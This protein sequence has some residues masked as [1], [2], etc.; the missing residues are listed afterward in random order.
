MLD[1]VKDAGLFLEIEIKTDSLDIP[2]TL[3]ELDIHN[4]ATVQIGYNEI[5][6][7][8]Y[9]NVIPCERQYLVNMF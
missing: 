2:S 9:E 4:L 6:S 5:I 8:K 3:K 1:E 7:S